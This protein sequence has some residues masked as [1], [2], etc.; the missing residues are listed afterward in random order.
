MKDKILYLDCFSGISGDMFLGALLD[1]GVPLSAVE[2]GL[3]QLGLADEYHLHAE[4]ITRSGI[5]GTSFQVHL[6][7]HENHH[8]NPEDRQ[9]KETSHGHHHDHKHDNG[10]KHDHD[11]DQGHHHD[12]KQVHDHGHGIS[13]DKNHGLEG[14]FAY[15]HNHGRTYADIKGLIENAPLAPEVRNKALAVFREIGVA[16]AAVHGVDLD[17]VH[18]HEVGAIDSI[19]DIVGAALALEY[20]QISRVVVSPISDGT[21][22]IKC[23]HGMM[24]VPVPAVMKMLEHTDIP[25]IT[26]TSNT[27]LVTPTG[28]GLAKTLASSFGPLPAMKC[29]GVGYGFGQREIG[30]LNAL[31][32][33]LGEAAESLESTQAN[34]NL[35][36]A[37]TQTTTTGDFNP[38]EIDHVV[39]LS[40]HI[41]NSTA[42]QLGFVAQ[43]LFEA[44][45]AD[46]TFS[47][48]QMKKNRPGQLLTVVVKPDLEKT[49]VATIFAQTGTIGIRRELFE[50]HV[51]QRTFSS[52]ELADGVIRLKNVHWQSISR[53][54]PEYDDLAALAMRRGISLDQARQIVFQAAGQVL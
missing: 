28:F 26:G 11:H 52:I 18:F 29:I 44:G 5:L 39:L 16:E 51:M 7:E 34:A 3:A 13:H 10:H 45:V 50:R 8:H 14:K 19:V 6:K 27:E 1:L 12:S 36:S 4:R 17:R 35:G 15:T 38:D 24:P 25:Y 47:P 20:L 31:R 37:A 30:H 49:A 33:M 23:Q 21:G 22:M 54:Y 43:M 42:E 48:I 9:D 46:V 32:V 41:D 53:T 2:T 40:C